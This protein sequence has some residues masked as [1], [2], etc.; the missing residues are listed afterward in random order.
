MKRRLVLASSL[1]IPAAALLL[2]PRQGVAAEHEVQ[3]LSKGP[4]D[5]R[6]WF[7]PAVVYAEPGDT[8]HFVPTDKGHNSTAV[9][10]PDGA[11]A[12]NGKLS[13]EVTVT[14][15]VPGLYAYKCTPHFGLGMVGL[16]VAGD[17]SVNLEVVKG[18]KYPGKARAVMAALLKEVE[19]H[20]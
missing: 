12:W 11:E 17:P 3:M 9:V 10:V 19:A 20:A 2:R 18:A 16:I 5:Q 7:E 15:A 1:L 14:L 8:I 4:E 6:N 13:Q